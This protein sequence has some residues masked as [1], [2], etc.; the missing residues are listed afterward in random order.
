MRRAP[1]P[2]GSDAGVVSIHLSLM[3]WLWL[4]HADVG[5]LGATALD[6]DM[7][8]GSTIC[9]RTA[10]LCSMMVLLPLLAEA[11]PGSHGSR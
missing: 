7:V 6:Y 9:C 10:T 5:G 8:L 1:F 3:G 2:G 11:K 4:R